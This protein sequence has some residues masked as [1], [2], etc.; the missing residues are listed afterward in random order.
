MVFNNKNSI[1]CWRNKIGCLKFGFFYCRENDLINQKIR[2]IRAL[3]ELIFFSIDDDEAEL[4]ENFAKMFFNQISE[5]NNIDFS[6]I[7]DSFEFS[8]I[9]IFLFATF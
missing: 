4:L 9:P 6:Q 1:K 8:S 2:T 7:L 5:L 3:D